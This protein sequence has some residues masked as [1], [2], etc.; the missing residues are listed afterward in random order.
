M[1]TGENVSLKESLEGCK[2]GD[3]VSL[4]FT[5]IQGTAV[6]CSESISITRPPG[7]EAMYAIGLSAG[8]T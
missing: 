3:K 8:I 4:L 2:S 5:T 7:L 6:L 1:T